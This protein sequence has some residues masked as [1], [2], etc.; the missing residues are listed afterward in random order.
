MLILDGAISDD[1]TL[2]TLDATESS[3]VVQTNEINEYVNILVTPWRLLLRFALFLGFLSTGTAAFLD[4]EVD[5]CA[6]TEVEPPTSLAD[7]ALDMGIMMM[8]VTFFFCALL[9]SY[10]RGWVMSKR[11]MLRL[12]HV[13]SDRLQNELDR[14]I[15]R[16]ALVEQELNEAYSSLY[17]NHVIVDRMDETYRRQKQ[18]LAVHIALLNRGYRVVQRADRELRQHNERC[19]MNHTLLMIPRD[20]VFHYDR[21]CYHIRHSEARDV[22]PCL[23]CACVPPTPYLP[24]GDG[25][26]LSQEIAAFLDEAICYGDIQT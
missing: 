5:Q 23:T 20:R 16:L 25:V 26:M 4:P 6:I 10:W 19:H 9:L 2:N 14:K 7:L 18:E 11:E 1:D 17:D 22:D 13:R 24:D 3:A 8:V 12:R 21:Q 15:S